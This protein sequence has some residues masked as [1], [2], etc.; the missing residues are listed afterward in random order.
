LAQ[1]GLEPR[2]IAV[3]KINNNFGV[4]SKRVRICRCNLGEST[5]VIPE[6]NFSK[7]DFQVKIASF[8]H[9]FD[10]QKDARDKD[11]TGTEF[12]EPTTV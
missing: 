6:R 5:W 9:D 2:E 10:I 1:S 3:S 4:Q 12:R 11:M 8:W 7:S